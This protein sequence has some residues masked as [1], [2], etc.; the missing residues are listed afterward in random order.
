MS[1][2]ILPTYRFEKEL[3]RLVRKFPSLKKEYANLLSQLSENPQSRTS[4]GNECFKIRLSIASKGKGKRGGARVITYIFIR[5]NT[6]YLLTIYDK[7]EVANVTAKDLKEL[8][9]AIKF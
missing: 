4:L 5:T 8:I 9:V 7:S 3:K 2:R 1:F 6:V